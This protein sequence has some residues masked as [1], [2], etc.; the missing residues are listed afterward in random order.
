MIQVEGYEED[1]GDEGVVDT[2]INANDQRG[3]LNSGVTE[4]GSVGSEEGRQSIPGSD[5]SRRVD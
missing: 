4:T 3:D 5:L 2:G 1:S